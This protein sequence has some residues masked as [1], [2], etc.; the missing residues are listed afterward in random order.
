MTAESLPNYSVRDLNAAIG[1]L[2]ERGFAPR[3]LVEASVS[4]PQI[5]KGHLWLTL[6]DGNASITAVAWASKLQQ[7]TYR[8][9]EG[10]GV[11]VV[12]KLNFWATRASLAVQVIDLR[13]SL[14]TVLRQFEIVKGLLLKEGIID[15]SKRKALPKYPEVVAILTS[16]P[17]SALADMLRTAKERWPLTQLL[18]IPIPVQG[19]VAKQ[20]QSVLRSL[21]N[22]HDELG[23]AAI[24]LARGGGSREDL[25]VF[26][27]E[28]LCRDLASFPIPVV[29]GLGHEDDQTVADLVADH[30]AATPTAAMVALLPSRESAQNVLIQRRHRLK[31]HCNWLIRKERERLVVRG[32]ALECQQPLKQIE[33]QRIHLSQKHQLL[34]ALSPELWLMRGFAIVKNKQ[35]KTLRSVGDVSLLDNLTIQLSDGQINATAEEINQQRPMTW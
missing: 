33:L 26:D 32:K 4:K 2:L 31:D 30:R 29:T 17:S 1:T 13:P 19:G 22:Q 25:M 23:I 27:D 18:I 28:D 34:Q 3:F 14:S 16:V 6:T 20:I 5:K 15:E 35:G 24:V 11:T 8:P 9:A 7:L 21:A 10:D 12:G